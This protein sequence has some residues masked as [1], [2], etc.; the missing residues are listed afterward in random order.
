MTEKVADKIWL[1][2]SLKQS[3]ALFVEILKIGLWII[4][5][6]TCS[7]LLV[8]PEGPLNPDLEP[9]NISEMF[10]PFQTLLHKIR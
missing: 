7:G 10:R 3:G 9:S 1:N 6:C 8:Y 2:S 5:L 4:S